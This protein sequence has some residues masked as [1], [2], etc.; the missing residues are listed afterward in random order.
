MQDLLAIHPFHLGKLLPI[1][2]RRNQ[3]IKDRREVT[4]ERFTG[5]MG[6]VSILGDSTRQVILAFTIVSCL[7]CVRAAA[8]A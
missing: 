8:D 1:L 2:E 5:E 7:G 6:I 3:S 4:V